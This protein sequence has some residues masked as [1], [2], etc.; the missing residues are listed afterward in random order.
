MKVFDEFERTDASSSKL[1]RSLFPYLNL[2]NNQQVAK[3]RLTI[4]EWFKSFPKKDKADLRERLRSLHNNQFEGAFFEL[5]L[6][7]LLSGMGCEVESHPS[8]EEVS[9]KLDFLVRSIDRSILLE[10]TI[11][12]PEHRP[13]RLNNSEQDIVDT[14]MTLT[15][16]NFNIGMD[17]EGKLTSSFSKSTVIRKFSKLIEE[18]DPDQVQGLIDERGIY[19]APFES[20]SD[21]NGTFTGWLNPIPA[22]QRT[23]NQSKA[24]SVFPLKPHIMDSSSRIRSALEKKVSEKR[25]RKFEYQSLPLVIAV[26]PIDPYFHGQ[27]AEAQVL[28]GDQHYF[29]DTGATIRRKNGFW[30]NNFHSKV[31]A[32]WF[33]RGTDVL[34]LFSQPSKATGCVY[35]KPL[36]DGGEMP[37]WLLDLPRAKFT[38]EEE[39]DVQHLVGEEVNWISRVLEL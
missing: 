32:V 14:L 15:S 35:L 5:V 18:N 38:D 25:T 8:V 33:F 26:N 34:N 22:N 13:F 20:L 2:S 3:I 39:E 37:Q 19:A 9:K 4:E 21:N 1:N 17:F 11:V 36:Y 24:I 29:A 12:D 6:H 30:R 23:G 28:Y 16:P 10:A 31:S 27:E 7:Q